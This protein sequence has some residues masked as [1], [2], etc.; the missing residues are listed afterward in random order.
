MLRNEVYRQRPQLL[1]ATKINFKLRSFGIKN[2]KIAFTGLFLLFIE[3][4]FSLKKKERN[5]METFL[6]VLIEDLDFKSITWLNNALI[7]PQTWGEI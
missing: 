1:L 3:K 2:Q 6:K 5:E 4:S 7:V